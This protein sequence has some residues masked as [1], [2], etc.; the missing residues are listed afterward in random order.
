MQNRGYRQPYPKELWH[1]GILGMKWGVRNGPPYPIARQ[2]GG[3]LVLGSKEWAER[4]E[5][6]NAEAAVYYDAVRI[7]DDVDQVAVSARM[8]PEEIAEVKSHIFTDTH[9]LY[10][11]VGR[12]DPDYD[13]AV[14]WKRLSEGRP[15][16]RDILLLQHELL[17]S[18]LEKQ[19]NWSLAQAHREANKQFN[20]SAALEKELGENGEEDGL[21]QTKKY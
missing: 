5:R 14:A 10:D 19:N 2:S 1:H 7:A 16:N 12:A 8:T 20:W 15:E 6:R 17:E 13:M 4:E 11:G 3:K 18:K 21:L 9:R